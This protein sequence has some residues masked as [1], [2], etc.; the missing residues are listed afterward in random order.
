M[1]LFCAF[2]GLYAQGSE[3]L[4]LDAN[5]LESSCA[6]NGHVISVKVSGGKGPYSYS[7]QDGA[8][9][10]FRK[11]LASGTYVCTV[12]D[13]NGREASRSFSFKAQPAA[14]ELRYTQEKS[15]EGTRIAVE[16]KGGRAPYNYFWIGKG[17]HAETSPGTNRQEGL[18]AGTY[19]VVVQDANECTANITV[20][21]Q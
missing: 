8:E 21:V 9:G 17:V 18:P 16:A 15:N 14:L 2:T 5:T 11:D 6:G 19:Q 13:A 10:S 7:W 1:L 20:N 3:P 12:R 4:Q